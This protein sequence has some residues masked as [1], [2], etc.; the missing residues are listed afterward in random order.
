M[1]TTVHIPK[2][3]LHAVDRLA[4]ALKVSRNRFIVRTLEQEV[5]A[6]NEWTPGFFDTV[7]RLG[8]KH[9]K[10]VDEMT[11]A[12]IANRSSKGPPRL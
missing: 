4:R 2:E 3:L 8:R 11:A 5:T 9:T 1:P 10:A 6:R 7:R 12:I